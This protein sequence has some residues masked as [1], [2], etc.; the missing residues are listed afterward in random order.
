M[1][2]RSRWLRVRFSAGARRRSRSGCRRPRRRPA[3]PAPRRRP[4]A[5]RPRRWRPRRPGD[6]ASDQT[7]ARYRPAP[8]ATHH[9]GD[10]RRHEQHDPV[11]LE[12]PPPPGRAG[13]G[14]AGRPGQADPLDPDQQ[15]HRRQAGQVVVRLGDLSRSRTSPGCRPPTTRGTRSGAERRGPAGGTAGRPPSRPGPIQGAVIQGQSAARISRC[16]WCEIPAVPAFWAISRYQTRAAFGSW[17]RTG[18]GQLSARA[19]KRSRPRP[20]AR[21]REPLAEPADGRQVRHHRQAR[22]APG[23]SAPWSGTPGRGPRTRPG[24]SP[25]PPGAR[26]RPGST[27]P[28]SRRQA[29]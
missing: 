27:S 13:P 29:A 25:G 28:C 18:T 8:P 1:A 3:G 7:Q 16:R 2:A 14:I 17:S 15:R 26:R 19:T 23:R 11:R 20:S 12:D 24:S 6:R 22:P 9:R 5:A 21:R 10:H 4:R